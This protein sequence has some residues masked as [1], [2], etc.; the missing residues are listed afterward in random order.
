VAVKKVSKVRR[1]RQEPPPNPYGGGGP[2]G[3][4]A[5]ETGA[6]GP[7]QGTGTKG[8]QFPLSVTKDRYKNDPMNYGRRVDPRWSNPAYLQYLPTRPGYLKYFEDDVSAP[9][10][11]GRGN[12]GLIA[13]LQRQLAAVGLIEGKAPRGV[14]DPSTENAY[15]RLLEIANEWG[16]SDKA[17]LERLLSESVGAVVEEK[18]GT[19]GR[20]EGGTGTGYTVDAEGNIVPAAL[21]PF[22][23]PA[24]EI[25]LPNKADTDRIVR[26]ASIDELGR[27]LPQES[28]DAI[29]N[30]Y[31]NEVTRLQTEAQ[32]RAIE[33]ER[34]LYETGTTDINQITSVEPPSMEAFTEQQLR[35]QHGPEMEANTGMELLMG[36]ISQWGGL[37][38]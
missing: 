22:Q 12:P 36:L 25:R 28:I 17:T 9:L 19:I 3:G 13:E 30:A 18:G 33:R 23:A 38:G 31:I 37:G 11:V 4:Q 35:E 8:K 14:W 15:R 32:T 7:T 20:G 21:P 29:S 27:G 26:R 1:R 24:L 34:Q 2:S 6:S 10:M 16:M 5:P